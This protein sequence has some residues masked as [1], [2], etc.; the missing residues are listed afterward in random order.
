M[1]PNKSA[2]KPIYQ[3]VN[4]LHKQIVGKLKKQK[5]YSLSRDNIWVADLAD[6]Q[7]LSKYNKGIKYL[8][9]A[10]D[11]FRNYAWIILLKDE[12][13]I[14]ILNAFQ[15]VISKGHKASIIWV[16]QVGEF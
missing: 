3:L 11:L 5:V 10:F 14:T 12:R 8:L 15:K 13:G 6:T 7:S 1:P 4:E 2:T 16:D 9:C